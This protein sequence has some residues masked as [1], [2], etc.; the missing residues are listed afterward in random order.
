MRLHPFLEREADWDTVRAVY[1]KVLQKRLEMDHGQV[2][3]IG[4]EDKV[5]GKITSLSRQLPETRYK[6]VAV[7]HRAAQALR[8]ECEYL[9]PVKAT[10]ANVQKSI[11]KYFVPRTRSIDRMAWE[12]ARTWMIRHFTFEKVVVESHEYGLKTCLKT[13]SSS[14]GLPWKLISKTKKHIVD[15]YTPWL[16]QYWEQIASENLVGLWM[17]FPKMDELRPK[18]KVVAG[19]IRTVMGIPVELHYA[20]SRLLG[21]YT[22]KFL[23]ST[24]T[25]SFVGRSKFGA[26]WTQLALR[27]QKHLHQYEFDGS[28]WDAT[29]M[30]ETI[31]DIATHIQSHWLP[32]HNTRANR[33]RMNVIVENIVDSWVVTPDGGVHRKTQGLPSGVAATTLFDTLALYRALAYAFI[34]TGGPLVTYERFTQTVEAALYGDDN[35]CAI[36]KEV[37][38]WFNGK[39][40]QT[41][42][43]ELGHE[44]R[45][46]AYQTKLEGMRFIGARFRKVT[47][48]Q[49]Y[50]IPD[51]RNTYSALT[52]VAKRDELAPLERLAGHRLNAWGSEEQRAN[53]TALRDAYLMAKGRILRGQ[54][55]FATVMSQWL[56]DDVIEAIY[57]GKRDLSRKE[58]GLLADHVQEY[59]R[60]KRPH[61]VWKEA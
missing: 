30:P 21:A 24:N 27:L 31:R 59:A 13:G 37:H 7:I 26:A 20:S 6:R 60:K 47:E 22:E 48:T 32:Q 36:S 29:L 52:W 40:I 23:E 8:L 43:G 61:G 39:T 12:K 11:E 16:E 38:P 18:E 28:A 54:P 2:T 58:E 49:W 5:V 9:A 3:P 1:P 25:W 53:I 45:I 17:A 14:P 56:E 15:R 50:P 44:L 33:R 10:F 42:F 55:R 46:D 4:P 35:T 19:K 41:A 51:A 57:T 34:R